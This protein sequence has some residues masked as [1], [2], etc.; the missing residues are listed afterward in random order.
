M[1]G[2]DSNK[3]NAFHYSV[4]GRMGIALTTCQDDESQNEN[5][6]E[7]RD[8]CNFPPGFKTILF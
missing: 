8:F 1:N 5:T 6:I 4:I 2:D 7:S 3:Q